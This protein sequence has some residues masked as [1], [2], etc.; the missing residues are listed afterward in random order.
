MVATV[1]DGRAAVASGVD[2][3]V[4]Q[5]SESGGHRSYGAKP[6]EKQ[7]ALGSSCVV[8]ESEF[9]TH[10]A[11]S[12]AEVL[13]GLLQSAAGQDL[14]G[15]AKAADDDQLQP[16]YAGAAVGQLTDIPTAGAVLDEMTAQAREI[17]NR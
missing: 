9:T 11:E 16:L 8:L 12:G 5:G 13:P 6:G 10:W 14:F 3:V 1:E 17:L 2:V 7:E 15:A 4:A